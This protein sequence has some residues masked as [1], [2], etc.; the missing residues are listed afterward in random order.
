MI[1][2]KIGNEERDYGAADPQW[3]N[4]SLNGHR[5]NGGSPCVRVTV[6]GDDV[7]MVLTT[8]ACPKGGGGRVPTQRERELFDLWDKRGLNEP[9]F[10]GGN[11]VAFLKQL[12]GYC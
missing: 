10:T 3:I 9:Q 4:Q 11:L 2:V 8:A 6:R 5:G 1:R 12:R 7:D